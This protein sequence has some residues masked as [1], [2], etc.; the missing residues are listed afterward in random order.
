MS[1][2]VVDGPVETIGERSETLGEAIAD[3]AQI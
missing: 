2:S 1:H 3:V